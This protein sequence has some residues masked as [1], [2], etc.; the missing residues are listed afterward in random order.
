[1]SKRADR[2]FLEDIQV[3]IKR[4]LDYTQGMD[5]ESFL[6][7]SQVQDA[8]VRNLEIIGEA[9]KSLSADFRSKHKDIPWSKMAKQRDRLIHHYT[10]VDYD[11]VWGII[12][13]S[14]RQLEPRIA[15]MLIDL[16]STKDNI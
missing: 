13:D 6:R 2:D 5:Y 7:N 11:I 16:S 1:M 14:L 10:G 8:V 15:A 12:E 9:T 3:C 4:I